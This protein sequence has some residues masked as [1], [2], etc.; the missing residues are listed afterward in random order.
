MA[1]TRRSFLQNTS[2][3]AFAGICTPHLSS[4]AWAGSQV[5][6]GA[7]KID[8]LSDGN[9]SLPSSYLSGGLP[10]DEVK[11]ILARY[12]IS[13]LQNTPDCN[14]T[15]VRDG[16]RTIIFDVGSG[17]NFMPSA[18]KLGDALDA[19]N[20]DAAS[21]THVVFTHAHPDHLWGVLDEFDDPFFPEANYMIGKNEWDY[22]VNP[23]TVETIGATRQSFA[24]GA[25]R[26]L[27]A[28]EDKIS[29]FK[30]GEEILPGVQARETPGHT[31][32]HMSFEVKSGSDSVMIVGDAIVNHHI[33]FERPNWPSGSDQDSALGAK[34]RAVLLD[35][36][37][38]EK[39]RIIGYHMPYPGIGYAE[40]KD[41]GYRFVAA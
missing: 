11:E 20:V 28:I 4:M 36:L 23:K 34:T 33:A 27:K 5:N 19:L 37:A 41:G 3:L 12:N 18:G 22:W 17:A 24:A 14:L 30:D 16:E 9:L 40:K 39:M 6:L 15:L 32:G 29:F 26:N 31:P 8:V 21:V 13:A 2:A 38:A 1:H 7:L 35:Q 25:A 10:V